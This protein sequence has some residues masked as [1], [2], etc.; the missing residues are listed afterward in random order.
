MSERLAI[1]GQV[2]PAANTDTDL[3]TVPTGRE[4]SGIL[5]V[6]NRSGVEVRFRVARRVG[7]AAL[8]NQHFTYHDTPLG[9]NATFV[10][11]GLAMQAG[12]VV[13]VR[14]ST[15]DVTFTLEGSEVTI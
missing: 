15:A 2:A 4:V 5:T 12:V 6:C 9:A 8:A 7:G 3:Y 13:T 14:A 10:R 11:A 1:L